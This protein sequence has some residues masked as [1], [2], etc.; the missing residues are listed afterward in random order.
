MLPRR[1]VIAIIPDTAHP[2]G[3]PHRPPICHTPSSVSDEH[4][5]TMRHFA[6]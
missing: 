2:H 1:R 4:L 6:S 3:R 5:L